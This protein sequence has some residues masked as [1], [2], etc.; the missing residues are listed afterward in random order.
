MGLGRYGVVVACVATTCTTDPGDE[1]RS[2]VFGGE[3]TEIAYVGRYP[4]VILGYFVPAVC[5]WYVQAWLEENWDQEG[6]DYGSIE[7]PCKSYCWEQEAESDG[8]SRSVIGKFHLFAA[9]IA[10]LVPT[11]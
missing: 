7:A 8:Q 1:T 9:F 4:A 5:A 11:V 2:R 10:A 3:R 6:G